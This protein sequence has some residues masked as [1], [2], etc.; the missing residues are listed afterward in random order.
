MLHALI[1]GEPKVVGESVP[2][3]SPRMS[4][5]AESTTG[6]GAL[7]VETMLAQAVE[8]AAEQSGLFSEP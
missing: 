8:V 2:D 7:S 4:T 3:G 1:G 6:E 5:I